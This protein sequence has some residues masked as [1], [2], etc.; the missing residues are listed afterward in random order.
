MFDRTDVTKKLSQ[1][2]A[3][4][5]LMTSGQE[6]L[7]IFDNIVNNYAD[8]NMKYIN[9]WGVEIDTF[10]ILGD[11]LDF[12]YIFE[13][14]DLLSDYEL[15]DHLPNIRA[16]NKYNV[17]FRERPGL[18]REAFSAVLTRSHNLKGYGGHIISQRNYEILKQGK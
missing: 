14:N 17:D 2:N 5:L 10:C 4:I 8:P 16:A 6:H 9:M 7:K 3:S 18:K 11:H 15:W 13:V 12:G 1:I